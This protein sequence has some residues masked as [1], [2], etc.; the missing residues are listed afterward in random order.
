MLSASFG[1][2]GMLLG[3]RNLTGGPS[4]RSYALGTTTGSRIILRDAEPEV[5]G[6]MRYDGSN[7]SG[8]ESSDLV[9][10]SRKPKIEHSGNPLSVIGSPAITLTPLDGTRAWSLLSS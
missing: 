4:P 9:T 3:T 1:T 7:Y 2:G 8:R 10:G 6:L 5:S